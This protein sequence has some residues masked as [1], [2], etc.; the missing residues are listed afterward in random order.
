MVRDN[1][2]LSSH[3]LEGLVQTTPF[4]ID[5]L[6]IDDTADLSRPALANLLGAGILSASR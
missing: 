4:G 5:S 6:I 1:P 3:A 2:F